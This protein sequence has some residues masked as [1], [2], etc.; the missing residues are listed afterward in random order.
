MFIPAPKPQETDRLTPAEEMI[1]LGQAAREATLPFNSIPLSDLP[2]AEANAIRQTRINLAR[3]SIDPN[4]PPDQFRM[5]SSQAASSPE[6]SAPAT[7][8]EIRRV[9]RRDNVYSMHFF[10]SLK[11][12]RRSLFCAAFRMLKLRFLRRCVYRAA[13]KESRCLPGRSGS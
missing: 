4:L 8:D 12:Q 9:L 6:M 10:W 3:Q 7:L 11:K 2:V 5:A 1:T 13:G